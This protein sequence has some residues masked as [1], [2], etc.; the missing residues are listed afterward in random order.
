MGDA[1]YRKL[2][3]QIRKDPACLDS[4]SD[5]ALLAAQTLQDVVSLTQ[6]A[7]TALGK[8]RFTTITKCAEFMRVILG[9]D[10][11]QIAAGGGYYCQVCLMQPKYDYHWFK[12][13][14]CGQLSGWLCAS[15]GEVYDMKRMAGLITFVDKSNP[16][17][18]QNAHRRRCQYAVRHEDHGCDP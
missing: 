15:C 8:G 4:T 6:K 13:Q 5:L 3:M 18:Y 17:E 7:R 1:G 9:D 12:A 2:V 16:D 11:T 10:H 14:G